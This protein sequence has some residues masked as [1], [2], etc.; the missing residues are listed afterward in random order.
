MQPADV[1]G[2][3]A[4]GLRVAEGLVKN[5]VGMADGAGGEAGLVQRSC[6]NVRS[7]LHLISPLTVVRFSSA[8]RFSF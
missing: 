8:A 6:S 4:I 1:L 3:E 5:A 2:Y 7:T